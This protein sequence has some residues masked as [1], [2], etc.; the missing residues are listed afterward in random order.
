MEYSSCRWCQSIKWQTCCVWWRRCPHWNEGRGSG[1]R[2]ASWF[3]VQLYYLMIILIAW[4]GNAKDIDHILVSTTAFC[5]LK[6]LM[7]S[8]YIQESSRTTWHKLIMWMHHRIQFTSSLFLAL[9][10]HACEELWSKFFFIAL[11][12]LPSCSFVF[13]FRKVIY[14]TLLGKIS[15]NVNDE[16]F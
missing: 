1:W 10:T 6:T 7:E 14:K 3:L 11:S 9:I 15:T 12:I 16:H 5:I 2:E 13:M 4:Y 8:V